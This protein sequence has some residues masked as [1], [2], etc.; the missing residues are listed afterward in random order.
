MSHVPKQ[1]IYLRNPLTR[2]FFRWAGS[3]RWTFLTYILNFGLCLVVFMIMEDMTFLD[4]LWFC[5]VS[6]FTV[7]YGDMVP[8]TDAGKIFAIYAIISA[9]ILVILVTANFVT[10]LARARAY[11]SQYD[12]ESALENQEEV[13]VTSIMS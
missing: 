10:K 6:W 2:L 8:Q 11:N 4:S 3:L 7:G 1:P 5:T 9:H 12:R 13:D